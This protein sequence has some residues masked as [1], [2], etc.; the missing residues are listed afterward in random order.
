VIGEDRVHL[1]LQAR[2]DAHQRGPRAREAPTLAH[3]WRRDPG[4]R[5]Q[6]RAQQV[7]EGAGIDAVVLDP[8]R[9]DGLGGKGM[10][11][12]RLDTG[13][14]EEISEPAPAIRRL[15]GHAERAGLE[16]A[17]DT[18]EVFGAARDTAAEHHR[19]VLG[20]RRHD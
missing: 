9:G 17:E 2:A 7:R 19:S 18:L 14:S 3:R 6:V 13:V 5:E 1:A 20:Q 12:V 11:H 16:L 8:S 15:E 4:L 10:G